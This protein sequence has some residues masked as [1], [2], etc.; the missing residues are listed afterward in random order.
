MNP[1]TSV[2]TIN[3]NGQ[4]MQ[5]LTLELYALF[6]R[7]TRKIQG[8]GKV[9]SYQANTDTNATRSQSINLSNKVY[10]KH[11]N[12]QSGKEF[13]IHQTLVFSEKKNPAST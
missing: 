2:T 7:D 10:W 8:H 9:E 4:K 6:T 5:K 13:V 12:K 3:V 1:K 11:H